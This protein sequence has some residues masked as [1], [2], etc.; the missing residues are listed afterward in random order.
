M[1][2]AIKYYARFA[3]IGVAAFLVSLIFFWGTN[4][5]V[6]S[7]LL[8]AGPIMLGYYLRNML[9]KGLE[10]N[11]RV[12]LDDLKDLLQAGVNISDALEIS[13]RNDYGPLSV[14][15]KRLAAKV[16]IGIPLQK[17]L[18]MTFGGIRSPLIRKIILVIDQTLRAGGNF[19]KVFITSAKYV[20]KIERLKKQR[21]ART[22]STLFNS[23]LMFYIFVLLIIV[24]QTF[25][26]P[27][28]MEPISQIDMSMLNPAQGLQPP[29]E[30][31]PLEIDFSTHFLN[32]LIVQSIFAGPM[33]GKIS[34][35][36]LVAGIKHSL[37]LLSTS[38]V[39]YLTALQVA[40][41]AA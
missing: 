27:T 39:V 15:V 32:L 3:A 1:N 34:E 25:F 7:F 37:I 17:A 31:E 18:Q 10:E 11:F 28:L 16:K 26:V 19:M 41:A 29:T 24:L 14:Y 23:Y 35:N 9:V 5:V 2:P 12:F 38:L 6:I 22:M 30:Q 13:A 40:G 4:L 33:I 21:T 8:L 36:N 20:D